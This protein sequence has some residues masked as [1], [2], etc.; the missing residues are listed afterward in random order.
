[1]PSRLATWFS[2]T[3]LPSAMTFIYYFINEL[4]PTGLAHL[5]D[6]HELILCVGP[7]VDF[8]LVPA[9]K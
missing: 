6:G 7:L 5:L 8:I 4:H 3:W 9:G 2:T 1:M